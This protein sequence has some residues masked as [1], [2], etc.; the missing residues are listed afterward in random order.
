MASAFIRNGFRIRP[1]GDSDFDW[2]ELNRRRINTPTRC[3]GVNQ[4]MGY[5]QIQ[6]YEQSKLFEKS[7]RD[8]LKENEAFDQLKKVTMK[9]I[10]ELELRRYEYRR[11][12]DL[13]RPTFEVERNL[14]DL[15]SLDQ[16]KK[17]VRKQ[18][19]KDKV[20]GTTTDEIYGYH[21][22]GCRR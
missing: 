1:L 19:T 21:Q 10:V 20:K 13:N 5:V 16:L 18:L 14:K 2:L 4:A 22:S 12:E 6:P 11:K 8:G 7:A 15:G 17:N 9:V 3:I